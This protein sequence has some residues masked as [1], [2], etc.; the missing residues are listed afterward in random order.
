MIRSIYSYPILLM[1]VLHPMYFYLDIHF[2][3]LLFGIADLISYHLLQSIFETRFPSSL[4]KQIPCPSEQ[5]LHQKI[6]FP[7]VSLLIL[8]GHM[9]W[10]IMSWPSISADTV[11]HHAFQLLINIFT[12]ITS[13]SSVSRYVNFLYIQLAKLIIDRSMP[14]EYFSKVN[15]AFIFPRY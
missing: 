14:I 12:C 5:M 3:K 8:I 15:N 9:I 13:I 11:F 2:L 1:P 6:F 10:I 7:D 4:L